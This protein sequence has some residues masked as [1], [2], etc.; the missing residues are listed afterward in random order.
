MVKPPS[1]KVALSYAGFWF[2]HLLRKRSKERL[3]DD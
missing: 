2:L 3:D 1:K